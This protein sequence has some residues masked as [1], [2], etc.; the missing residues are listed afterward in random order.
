MIRG[1]HLWLAGLLLAQLLA[2]PAFAAVY[3]EATTTDEGG[4]QEDEPQ[5]VKMR[6]WVDGPRMKIEY[7]EG[8]R[9]LPSGSYLLTQDG[10]ETVYFVNPQKRGYARWDVD[11]VIDRVAKLVNG[12]GLVKAQVSDVVDKTVLEEAGDPILGLPTVHRRRESGYTVEYSVMGIHKEQR[13]ETVRDT[14]VTDEV[15]QSGFDALLRPRNIDTGNVD[16]DRALS[17]ELGR[18]EGFTLR[19]VSVTTTRD[20]KGNE[21]VRHSTTEVTALREQPVDASAFELPA[22]FEE[23]PIKKLR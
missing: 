22:G 4:P 20:G 12:G 15:D 1:G 11:E 3:Y 17:A 6:A 19:S 13:K 7:V 9:E 5:V 21:R 23:R 16:L 8:T 14:W 10:G 2:A 18:A